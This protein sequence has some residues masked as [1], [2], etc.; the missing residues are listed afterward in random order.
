MSEWTVICLWGSPGRTL[1]TLVQ[2]NISSFLPYHLDGSSPYWLLCFTDSNKG[3]PLGKLSSFTNPHSMR[4]I[5]CESSFSRDGQITEG[6]RARKDVGKS[7][8]KSYDFLPCKCCMSRIF[9][10][11]YPNTPK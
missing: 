5:C 8:L 7:V 9:N 4:L 6:I 2:Y 3:Q 10:I 11:V 1:G